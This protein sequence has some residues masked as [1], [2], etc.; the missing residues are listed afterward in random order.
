MPGPMILGNTIDV[1]EGFPTVDLQTGANSGDYIS[2]RNNS[3]IL[4]LFT[5]GVGTGGDDPTLTI[6]QATDACGTSVKALNIVTS[7]VSAWKKQAA[8]SLA[9]TTTWTDASCCVSTN[10]LTNAT[11]AEQSAMW[12]VEFDAAD[13]DVANGF[14]YVRATVADVG[15]N[16]Q[17]GS[18]TYIVKPAYAEDPDNVLTS[19]S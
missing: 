4:I 10:T 1:V 6:Q 15:S 11:S 13:L 9:S 5:S 19:L 16:T 8:T 3:R 17:P 12:A 18:L 7:P 14:D 2:M